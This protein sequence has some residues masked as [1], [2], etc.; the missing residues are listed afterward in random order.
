MEFE[1]NT[2]FLTLIS[3][4]STSWLGTWYISRGADINGAV[5]NF[6]E[7]EQIIIV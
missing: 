2:L 6:V 4:K 1:Q 7:T 3:R 5:S